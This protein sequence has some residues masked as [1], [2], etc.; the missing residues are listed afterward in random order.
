MQ[1]NSSRISNLGLWPRMALA[2]SAGF[3]I[4]FLAFA[5][6]GE[7]ALQDSTD[8]LLE[9]RLVIA[10]ITAG[11]IDSLLEQAVFALEQTVRDTESE[12]DGSILSALVNRL[13]EKAELAMF[14]PGLILVDDKGQVAS[15]RPTE[16]YP[17][18]SDLSALP[19]ISQAL[20]RGQVTIS[21]PY[22]DPM[23]GQSVAAIATPLFENNQL[24]GLF[25]GLINLSGKDVMTP[26]VQASALLESEHAA[27]VDSQGRVIVSTFSLP[28]LSLGEHSSFYRRAM[29]GGISVVET[30]PFELDLPGEPEGHL[31][32]MALVPLKNAPWGLAVGGDEEDIF[33]GV[34]R[35][36]WGLVLLGV[37]A[38]V[39]VWILTLVG[40][41]RLVRPVQQLTQ[42]ADQIAAGNLDVRLQASGGGEIGVMSAALD[43]M[44]SQLLTNMRA[45]AE[46]NKALEDQ[47][48]EQTEDLRRQQAL[49][50]QLLRKLI[51][52]QESE[53]SHLARE[54]HDEIGQTLT[55][56]EL[57]LGDLANTLPTDNEEARRR[58]RRSR[59]LIER[60]TAELRAIIT[61]LRPATLDQLGL[62]PALE[63]IGD[64][65]LLPV[66]IP[67]SVEGEELDRRLPAE[68]ETTLFRIAQEAMSNVGRH[69]QANSLT[70]HLL[71]DS[72]E[73]TMTLTDDGQGFAVQPLVDAQAK[74][75]SLGIAGMQERA[76]LAGG[77]LDITSVPGE[78]TTLRVTIPLTP[79]E[80]KGE[81]HVEST[82]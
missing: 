74:G 17:A 42:A 79:Q 37:T 75:Q 78:G 30:V 68:V 54:L 5:L 25:I 64:H 22:L 35:L 19:Y 56:I 14:S 73:V 7:R 67:F 82:D 39:G 1:V 28:P 81:Y 8:R 55:A 77:K 10:Q 34:Q 27:I 43:R 70:I 47:V 59:A 60:T 50:Q 46:W 18:G 52:A 51:N 20:A 13:E 3:I 6:L 69:S 63:W 76:A 4:L 49:T 26:L 72:E 15:S 11:Q 40:T 44:R 38:L 71:A 66:G 58:L 80:Q 36:R 45:L 31:H 33:A 12:P 62:L 16:L 23:N 32:V 24:I 61:A 48:A 65:T 41:R 21:D 57:S 2:V 9:E 53:R 29:A